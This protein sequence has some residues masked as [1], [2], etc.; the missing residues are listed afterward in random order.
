MRHEDITLTPPKLMFLKKPSINIGKE[1]GTTFVLT[2]ILGFRN[3]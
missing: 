3:L 1:K 2:R